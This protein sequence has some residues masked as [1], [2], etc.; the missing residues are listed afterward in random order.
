MADLYR[1][2]LQDNQRTKQVIPVAEFVSLL[3]SQLQAL[4]LTYGW[5]AIEGEIRDLKISSRNHIYFQ[6][7]NGE[8][9]RAVVS[10]ASVCYANSNVDTTLLKEGNKVVAIGKVQL[11]KVKG[12]LQF[13]VSGLSLSGTGSLKQQRAE[14]L[15]ELDRLGILRRERK[16]LPEYPQRVGIVT[17]TNGE[18]IHDILTNAR[19]RQDMLDIL[20]YP[21]SVQGATA[22]FELISGIEFFNS[23]EAPKVDLILL[24]RGGGSA[25]DFSCFDDLQLAKQIAVSSIPV[26]TAIGHTKDN[27][28]A[29]LVAD[30]SFATPTQAG[31][32]IWPDL[33]IANSKAIIEQVRVQNLLYV[34]ELMQ[35]QR[36][37]IKRTFLANRALPLHNIKQLKLTLIETQESK[38]R[39]YLQAIKR[40]R[41]RLKQLGASCLTQCKQ[42]LN[43]Q[44]SDLKRLSELIEFSSPKHI[45][46]QGY[47]LVLDQKRRQIS[48]KEQVTNLPLNLHFR[49]GEVRVIPLRGQDENCNR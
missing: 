39:L 40:E 48:S 23:P 28:I 35:R 16:L 34:K 38:R 14:V 9:E 31:K 33:K 20:V 30:Y 17:S 1:K 3:E 29:D 37:E 8:A 10:L 6:L 4:N 47:V 15:S 11:Y 36:G 45:L 18:V 41:L 13:V 42:T 26:A 22:A 49:D 27:T 7:S 19:S 24:A 5:I 46:E 32:E 25:S 44:K 21:S 12:S 2:I 43:N